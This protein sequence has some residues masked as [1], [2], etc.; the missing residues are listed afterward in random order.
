M[1]EAIAAIILI[2]GSMGLA[3]LLLWKIPIL[4]QLSFDQESCQEDIFSKTK[5]RVK[6][7]VLPDSFDTKGFL[8]K[9]LLRVRIL[10]LKTEN[11]TN[12]LLQRLSQQKEGVK[13]NYW[14]ELKKTNRST[15]AKI[16][17]KKTAKRSK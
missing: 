14:E 3:M 10:S 11:K 7:L 8:Q 12:V 9:I 17:L 13:D 6:K 2:C 4:V 16:N 1:I 5:K 15:K